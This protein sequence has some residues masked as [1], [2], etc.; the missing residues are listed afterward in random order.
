M[1]GVALVPMIE[2]EENTLK[3]IL[4]FKK[5]TLYNIIFAINLCTTNYQFCTRFTYFQRRVDANDKNGSFGMHKF[6]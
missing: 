2:V 3:G 4:R 6:T 5:I 1:K